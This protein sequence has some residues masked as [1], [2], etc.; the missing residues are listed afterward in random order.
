MSLQHRGEYDA[1]EDDVVLTDEVY[2][3]SLLVL[4]ILLPIGRKVLSSRDI[5]DR[6]V[7]PY[8]QHLTL[9]ALDRNGD[10][11][12]QIAAYGTRLQ[13]RIEPRL[14]L[15]IDVGFPLLVALQ[16]P[17]AQERIVL[18]QRKI[19]ML[20]LLLNGYRTR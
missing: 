14:T 11:P 10:S 2:H 6:C 13:A 19:P 17:L 18:I 15:A 12:I 7:K 20:G 9:F 8:V 3:L 4:P 5:A 16:N 1:V